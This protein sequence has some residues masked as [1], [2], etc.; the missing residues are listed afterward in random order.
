MS[1]ESRFERIKANL[2][3]KL[4]QALIKVVGEPENAITRSQKYK[5]IEKYWRM[6]YTK[7]MAEAAVSGIGGFLTGTIMSVG[8]ATHAMRCIANMTYAYGHAVGAKV[9][10]EDFF[11]VLAF[12]TNKDKSEVVNQPAKAILAA[13]ARALAAAN[14]RQASIKAGQ[15]LI[16]QLAVYAAQSIAARWAM[17]IVASAAPLIGMAVMAVIM[18]NDYSKIT[19][20]IREFYQQKLSEA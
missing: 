17:R 11:Y 6:Q 16:N 10:K 14:A 19:A 1:D 13:R 7:M 4:Y 20:A 3:E 18:Q 9:D 15:Q 2:Q 12:W 5:T 8:T